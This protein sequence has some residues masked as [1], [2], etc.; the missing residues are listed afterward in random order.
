MLQQLIHR[1]NELRVVVLSAHDLALQIIHCVDLF[2]ELVS[3][4]AGID[5]TDGCGGE[6]DGGLD[7]KQPEMLLM[8]LL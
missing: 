7:G 5:A 6:V 1:F 3:V 4:P 2:R 8:I